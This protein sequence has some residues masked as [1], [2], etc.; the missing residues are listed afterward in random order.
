MPKSLQGL[1]PWVETRFPIWTW[2]LDFLWKQAFRLRH[3]NGLLYINMKTGFLMKRWK[4]A[5]LCKHE[6]RLFYEK[7]KTGFSCRHENRL[8]QEKS[9]TGFPIQTRK[10][11]FLGE[12]GNIYMKKRKQ[13]FL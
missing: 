6:N 4:H 12:G 3:G 7:M 1:G 2:K 11:A 8:S 13:V 10:E 5:F 9:E